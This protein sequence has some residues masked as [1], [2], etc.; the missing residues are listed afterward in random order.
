MKH[1]DAIIWKEDYNITS[2]RYTIESGVSFWRVRLA[3]FTV[4][5]D[6]FSTHFGFIVMFD[7]CLGEFTIVIRGL[8]DM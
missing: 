5:D 6:E 1:L 4:N 3:Q 2:L 7:I 8:F